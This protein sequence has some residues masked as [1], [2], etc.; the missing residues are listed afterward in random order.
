M[1][2]CRTKTVAAARVA[3]MRASAA[4]VDFG[5]TLRWVLE[6]VWKRL[7]S[8]ERVTVGPAVARYLAV[9]ESLIEF[10]AGFPVAE[11]LPPIAEIHL[12]QL[13]GGAAATTLHEGSYDGL[14]EAYAALETWMAEQ[15]HEP[16]GAPYDIYWVDAGQADAESQLRTEVVWPVRAAPG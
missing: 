14:P 6:T 4:P 9:S 11:E 12:G 15:G 16:D 2:R 8:L 1:H 10:E 3:L 13:P 7:S 5:P